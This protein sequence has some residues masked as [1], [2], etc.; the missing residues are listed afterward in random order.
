MSSNTVRRWITGLLA[1]AFTWD[2]L[3]DTQPGETTDAPPV[4]IRDGAK[5]WTIRVAISRDA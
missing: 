5:R 4:K 2:Q 3:T 1:A